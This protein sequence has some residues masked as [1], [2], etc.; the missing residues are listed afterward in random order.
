[1]RQLLLAFVMAAGLAGTASAETPA[2]SGIAVRDVWARAT[3]GGAK[4]GAIYLTVVNH[5]AEGDRLV[6]VATPLAEEAQLHTESIENGIMKM[7]P[8]KDVELKPGAT[9]VLRPG[10][11]HVMLVR[12]KHPLTEGE[13]FPLTLDFAKAGKQEV[14]VKV[15]KVGA[16]GSQSGAMGSHDMSHMDS[17]GTHDMSHMDMMKH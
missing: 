11:T 16:M 13:S 7:R 12:L 3:P 6:S 10:A 1:M 15:A 17:M 2:S 8:L 14:Q 5:G 9:T 4:T